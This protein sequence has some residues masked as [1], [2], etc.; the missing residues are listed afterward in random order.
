MQT[1]NN[2]LKSKVKL[3]NLMKFCKIKENEILSYYL[4]SQKKNYV[5]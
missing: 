1:V 3:K 5:P 2:E 4:Y